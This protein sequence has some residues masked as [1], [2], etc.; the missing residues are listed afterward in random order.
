MV[1]LA[2]LEYTD[3]VLDPAC[4]TGR[5]LIYALEDMLDKVTGV[6]ASK[7]EEKI[8]TEQL[9]GT[10]DDINVAKL[11]KMNM[12]IHDDGKTNIRDEDGLLLY[13][14]DNKIDVILTNPPLGDL[15][16]MKDTYD[17]D[18]RLKRTEVI[19]RKN[20]T[21]DILVI[22]EERLDV[23]KKKLE[24]AKKTKNR[25]TFYENKIREYEETVTECKLLIK[26][27][28]G[29]YKTTGNLMKGGAL[30]TNTSK[31]YL[32]NVRDENALPEWR[33][34]KLL[35]ILDEGV[36]NTDNYKGVRDFIRRYFYIKAIISLTRDAFVPVS[37]TTTKT[38]ILY[39]IKKEDPDATQKEPIF[40]AHA[41]KVGIN[42]RKKVCA[43]HLEP[44]LEKYFEFKSKVITCYE[45]GIQFNQQR[46][47][48]QG[49]EKGAI[50][51]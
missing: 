42:T 23:F 21:E 47:L 41:E 12:Y 48:E 8:K 22:Y 1:K 28:K 14:C 27:K 45:D 43:D 49:F 10:D 3:V 5:F 38:S 13:E 44:I 24:E 51:D 11:A 29:E 20:I 25:V 26:S 18:F 2:E 16:Y 36:L 4:G 31:H 9:Y 37:S 33:G 50:N 6:N 30:F 34:G 15:T 17:D 19:P 32:K 40:F 35:I 39:A 7:Q 46:F